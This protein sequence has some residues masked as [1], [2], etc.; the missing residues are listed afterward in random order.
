[1]YFLNRFVCF[2]S[3]SAG[4]WGECQISFTLPYIQYVFM[5]NIVNLLW[6]KDICV[7]WDSVLTHSVIQPNLGARCEILST[8]LGLQNG[9]FLYQQSDDSYLACR[10]WWVHWTKKA[11]KLQHNKLKQRRKKKDSELR[12]AVESLWVCHYKPPPLHMAKS[13]LI[14][15]VK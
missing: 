10:L 15:L 4:N 1:M 3:I 9:F 8:V 6:I 2:L 12:G 7:Y 5:L 11:V 13:F 14:S